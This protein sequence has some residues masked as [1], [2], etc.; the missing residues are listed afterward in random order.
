VLQTGDIVEIIS[1]NAAHPT[2][3]WLQIAQ[4]SR[5]RNKIRHW[6]KAHD[7]DY[8]LER[9]REVFAA[10][11]RVKAPEMEEKEALAQM[12]GI[13]AQ[14]SLGAAED[15]LVEI[16]FGS[17]KP[18]AVIARLTRPGAGAPPPRKRP[19]R[20][21][22]KRLE[23]EGILVEGMPG[24]IWRLA[25]CCAPES[26]D[27][28]VGFVTQGRGVSIHHAACP[29]LRRSRQIHSASPGRIVEVQWSDGAAAPLR[30]SVR[31]VAQDRQGLLGDVIGAI[32]AMGIN[33]LNNQSHT[34]QK[35]HRAIIKMTVHA[36][37]ESELNAL[38]KRIESV[39]HV[40]SV[41]R[42]VQSR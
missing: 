2:R 32:S 17:L 4:T 8:Y 24:A 30:V 35:T 39:P 10:D 13:A 16:G 40:R 41:S 29:M 22:R 36:T 6:L 28:I 21:L 3:D 12:S 27:P 37:D 38:M 5:A 42:V 9:G 20:K 33:I 26:G 19:P 7:R 14:L 1:S 11:L 18:G 31:V 34:N 23:K 15:V 25:R